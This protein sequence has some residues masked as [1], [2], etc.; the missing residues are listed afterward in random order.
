MTNLRKL[1]IGGAMLLGLTG[2]GNI[3]M[4]TSEC[5]G[6]YVEQSG[7]GLINNYVISQFEDT[8]LT[9]RDYTRKTINWNEDGAKTNLRNDS[10]DNITIK[11]PVLSETIT[12]S[13]SN[14]N[15]ISGRRARDWLI[16]RRA[17]DWLIR[18]NQLYLGTRECFVDWARR[19]YQNTHPQP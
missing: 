8:T 11:T 19:N 7:L 2:C 9:L 1:L 5:P 15:T 4:K 12:P 17:R 6:V 3:R 16:G 10:I 13:D 14:S 18:G